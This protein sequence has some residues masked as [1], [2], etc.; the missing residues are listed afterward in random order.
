M[1][2]CGNDNVIENES[3]PQIGNKD[4]DNEYTFVL[5]TSTKTYHISTCRYAINI[6]KDSIEECGD[7]EFIRTRGYKPCSTCLSFSN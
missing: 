3:L 2:S 1:V 7:L 4:M 6:N 5:N